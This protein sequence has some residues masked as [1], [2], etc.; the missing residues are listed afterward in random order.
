MIDH[1]KTGGAAKNPF[2][3]F[4]GKTM[5]SANLVNKPMT[6]DEALKILNLSSNDL[7]PEKIMKVL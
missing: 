2:T 4:I 7:T 6:S 1:I 3:D 5:E